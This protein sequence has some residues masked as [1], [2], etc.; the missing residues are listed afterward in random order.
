MSPKPLPLPLPLPVPLPRSFAASLALFL[1]LF[2]TRLS[3]QSDLCL[4]QALVWHAAQQYATS[5]QPEHV[6]SV[7]PFLGLCLHSPHTVKSGNSCGIDD[8][9]LLSLALLYFALFGFALCLALLCLAL[10][11]SLAKKRTPTL[12]P[13]LFLLA[14]SAYPFWLYF[15]LPLCT[16]TA[17]C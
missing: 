8:M 10:L 6:L 1:S 15:C 12:L 13:S 14:C 17:D 5:P 16:R 2:A 3:L 9:A 11:V 4:S 7:T